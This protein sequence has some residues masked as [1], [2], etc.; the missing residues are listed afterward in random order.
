MSAEIETRP[1]ERRTLNPWAWQDAFGFVQANEVTGAARTV[2]CAGQTSV[3]EEGRP[4]H[5]GDMGRQLELS[6]DNLETVLGAAGATLGDVVRLNYYTT[7][8]N[9]LIGVWSLLRERLSAA[10]CR[11]ASSLLGV[12][13]ARVPGSHA[14]DRSDGRRP[15][16]AARLKIPNA[17]ARDLG[18]SLPVHLSRPRGIDDR[19][20]GQPRR[21]AA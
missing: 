19:A 3:D 13:G 6:L 2:Y 11:P 7:D 21:I 1:L 10:G 9:G 5:P 12:A 8:V 16:V 20:A 18:G 14:R 15:G 4:M 17:D